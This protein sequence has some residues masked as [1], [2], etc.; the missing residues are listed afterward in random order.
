MEISA[1]TRK[2]HAWNEDRFI[3]GKNF[4]IVID[5]ATPLIKNESINLA[6]FLVSFVKKNIN[7]YKLPIKERLINLSK[8]AYQYLN[9]DT[10]DSAYLPSA[11]LSWVEELEDEYH[12][13]ILG[14]CEVTVITKSDEIIRYY[15]DNLHK[16]DSNAIN[17]MIEIATEKRINIIDAKEY[18]K[19]ILIENRKKINQP[20][21]YSAYTISKN[22]VINE[23]S[24]YIKKDEVKEIYL[25]SDGFS[26]SF[27]HLKIYNS[28]KDMFKNSLDLD[29]E[30]AKIKETAFNDP[31]CN[32]YPRFKKIDDITVV[33]IK[34]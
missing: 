26:Q 34:K 10:D 32:K 25:Y 12:I 23:K 20:N 33:K 18:I 15:S 22:L 1:R 24:F 28:H 14:D 21:G 29:L 3:I 31:Y 19:D 7:K 4:Y 2:A 27:E 6:K 9:L 8:D 11:S 30:I 13:G 5:G 17:K 16:F